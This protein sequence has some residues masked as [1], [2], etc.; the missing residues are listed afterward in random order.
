MFI[1]MSHSSQLFAY[2]FDMLA[3]IPIATFIRLMTLV[4]A[5]HID[6]GGST[7]DSIS[8]GNTLT[9]NPILASKQRLRWTNELH[10]RFIDAVAQLGGPDREFC[11]FLF[12]AFHFQYF[13]WLDILMS[14]VRSL[15]MIFAF[16]RIKV[17]KNEL[18]FLQVLLLKVFSE[19][20]VYRA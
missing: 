12:S 15:C 1:C 13:C 5:Q 7:M 8:G 11:V 6:C 10:Q 16:L 3:L 18:F 19:L 2:K 4:S 20:W 9:N 17:F 14:V